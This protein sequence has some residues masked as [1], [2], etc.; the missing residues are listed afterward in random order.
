MDDYRRD[1]ERRISDL[2]QAL[3]EA[4]A[5][6]PSTPR[7]SVPES[8]SAEGPAN[9]TSYA[10]YGCGSREHLLRNCPRKT[11]VEKKAI[12]EK[13]E[14][15]KANHLRSL[16]KKNPHTCLWIKNRRRKISA[17]VDTGNDITVVGTELAKKTRWQIYPTKESRVLTASG[18]LLLITGEVRQPLFIG[19]RS[20][21][22]V[23]VYVSPDYGRWLHP[24]Y[25][26]DEEAR[27]LLLGYRE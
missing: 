16:A 23:P 8:S 21:D 14:S 20:L 10:W 24:W 27:S 5:A 2:Q 4:T 3:K 7:S 6:S 11:L 12:W 15:P 17:L 26:L 1:I 19:S 25:G 9:R 22:E 13:H 18:E